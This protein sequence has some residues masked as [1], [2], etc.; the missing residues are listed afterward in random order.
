MS[1][2]STPSLL[3]YSP[4]EVYAI[5]VSPDDASVLVAGGRTKVELAQ[6]RA[7][8]KVRTVPVVRQWDTQLDYRPETI[9]QAVLDK[10]GLS[11]PPL[12]QVPSEYPAVGVAFWDSAD[13]AVICTS[14]GDI[15][16][17]DLPSQ[18][19][20]KKYELPDYGA[21]ETFECF[22]AAPDRRFFVAAGGSSDG[23]AFAWDA[24]TGRHQWTAKTHKWP[25]GLA[26]SPDATRVAAVCWDG[27]VFLWDAR[28]GREIHPPR[29]DYPYRGTCFFS[30]VFSPDGG[31]LAVAGVDYA[32][33][34][35]YIQLFDPHG[36]S[37]VREL[38]GHDGGVFSLAFSPCGRWLAS[39]G[40]DG[41]LA[42]WEVATGER[43]ALCD[44]TALGLPE[45]HEGSLFAG[46]MYSYEENFS[47]SC[48]NALAFTS[49]GR[50]IVLGT[51][52]G[53]I[54]RADVGQA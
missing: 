39:G 50:S 38:S 4:A 31:L 43:V 13:E 20:K 23:Y 16:L 8:A 3:G 12:R 15:A 52:S 48:V 17:W 21:F 22:A 37:R 18:R 19:M 45:N 9:T 1:P 2:F 26:V 14:W 47:P 10:L 11:D 53:A 51:H 5:A 25:Y 6:D 27:Q 36:P 41:Q 34:R 28:D 42:L 35:G 44:L 7:A 32:E 29:W 24:G 40:K 30:A 49:S 33:K 46:R 54:L